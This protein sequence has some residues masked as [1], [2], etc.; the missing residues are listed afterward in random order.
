MAGVDLADLRE[1]LDHKD[2]K[3]TPRCAQLLPARKKKAINVRYTLL[4]L[5]ATVHSS[6]T[7][8]K[9]DTRNKKS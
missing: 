9:T 3:V 6:P 4:N 7:A 1:L 8:T 5:I 2:I